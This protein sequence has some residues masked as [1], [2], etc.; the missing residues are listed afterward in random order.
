MRSPSARNQTQVEH[1]DLPTRSGRREI[2]DYYL[3]KKAHEAELDDPAQRA[4]IVARLVQEQAEHKDRRSGTVEARILRILR[5]AFSTSDATPVSMGVIADRFNATHGAEYGQP[6]S[7]K[8]VAHVV[9]KTLRLSTR[10]SNG[11]FIV[12]VSEKP[13][14]DALSARYT[15]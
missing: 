6:V 15:L 3:E 7:D 14:I 1:G 5:E 2:I 13:K 12:P 4:E 10:K 11:V 9:R 8:W